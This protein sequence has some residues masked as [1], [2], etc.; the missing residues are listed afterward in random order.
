MYGQTGSGQMMGTPV[1]TVMTAAGGGEETVAAH[2]AA[3]PSA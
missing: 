1:Q 3:L 2:I